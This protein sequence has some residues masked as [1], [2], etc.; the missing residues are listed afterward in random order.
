MRGPGLVSKPD[1]SRL[2]APSRQGI[3]EARR[4][5]PALC[6]V[7]PGPV[8]VGS[9][10][11]CFSSVTPAMVHF[12][13]VVHDAVWVHRGIA[14]FQ[15]RDCRV[16]LRLG[17]HWRGWRQWWYGGRRI[18]APPPLP[19]PPWSARSPPSGPGS[20]GS[21]PPAHFSCIVASLPASEFRAAWPQT[22]CFPAGDDQ[23][24]RWRAK[25]VSVRS[26]ATCAQAA[27]YW[28]PAMRPSPM[29]SSLAKAWCAR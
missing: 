1:T 5:T 29:A 15:A 16:V 12:A 6:A 17:F 7:D 10:R 25:N 8:A 27:S 28:V 11:N 3:G 23:R 19:A 18:E 21:T 14:L 24:Q 2:R 26:Q 22:G 4:S 9:V 13:L 20:S